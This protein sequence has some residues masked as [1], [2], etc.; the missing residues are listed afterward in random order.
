MLVSCTIQCKD[1]FQ[2]SGLN[3]TV[4][5]LPEILAKGGYRTA[6]VGDF[7]LMLLEV[8]QT[9]TSVRRS[10]Y[11]VF[12][13]GKWHLGFCNESFL[14]NNRGFQSFFGQYTYVSSVL[15][16][17]NSEMRWSIIT[18][19]TGDRLLHKRLTLQHIRGW[20]YFDWIHMTTNRKIQ[21]EMDVALCY[22]LFIRVSQIFFSNF[23]IFL[24]QSCQMVYRNTTKS[25]K[26]IDQ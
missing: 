16:Y 15:M 6:M 3:A 18:P 17:F 23:A 8:E 13:V 10:Q 7:N 21:S 5:L 25:F 1:F 26:F 20:V 2:P 11:F 9:K 24:D 22:A 4:P 19:L 14:P 12:K